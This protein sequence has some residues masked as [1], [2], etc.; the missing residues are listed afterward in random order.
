[1]KQ[2]RSGLIITVKFLVYLRVLDSEICAKIDNARA[3]LNYRFGK[4]RSEA[5]R[6]REKNNLCHLREL[7]RIR[8]AEAEVPGFLVVRKTR[9]NVGQPL[10]RKLSR[11]DCNKLRMRMSQKQPHKLFANVTGCADHSDLC[12]ARVP[13]SRLWS[14][15]HSAQC[16]FG[17][18]PIATD[19][20]E[21]LASRNGKVS[22]RWS[23]PRC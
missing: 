2:L 21:T 15:F 4:F 12:L 7:R 23:W 5:V 10:S 16:V 3:S 13:D 22:S 6:Q 20:C 17:F 8:R 11:R 18:D 1:A 14:F 19:I 9:K